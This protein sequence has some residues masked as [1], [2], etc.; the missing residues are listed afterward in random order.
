[1]SAVATGFAQQPEPA[2]SEP[3][4]WPLLAA[5][6]AWL[7]PAGF[8]LIAAAGVPAERAWHTALAGVAGSGLA[9]LA[10]FLAGFAVAFG[11]VGLVHSDPGYNGLIWEWTLLGPDWGPDWGMAG[12][13]GWALAGP[14]ATSGAQALFFAQLPWVAMAALAPLL[15]LRGRTP[16]AVSLLTGLIVGGILYPLATNWIW[17]GGWLANLGVT[18]NLGHGF[19]DFAGAGPVHVLGGIMALTGLLLLV[20]RRPRRE[21]G[22]G[23]SVPLPPV[24]LPLLAGV[25][26]LLVLAGSLGWGWANPLL[27]LNG[28]QP[29]RGAVNGVLAALGGAL[30]PLGYVWFATGRP[31][32]LMTAKGVAAGAIVGAAVGPFA[33]P[34]AALA[35]GALAGALVPLLTFLF[36]ELLRLADDTGVVAVHVAGGLLGIAGVGLLA[37]GLAGAGWNGIGAETYLGAAGQGV[38]GLLAASGFHPD[39]PGQFQAQA[40][41]AIILLLIPLLA[42]ALLYGPAALLERGLRLRRLAGQKA[43]EAAIAAIAA[44]ERSLSALAV[45]PEGEG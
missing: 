21:S 12:L 9:V 30:L 16:A 13:A 38:T 8:T 14:A 31:D 23:E 15:A 25:G 20:P 28:L 10:F 3:D 6:L 22:D 41:G 45:S 26:A 17:G 2:A 35:L 40:V 1:M 39:W 33:P 24:H 27:E 32:A 7:L 37:D 11:G 4:L 19:V 42:G 44:E 43:T 34:W 18:L 5:S 29:M 36:R